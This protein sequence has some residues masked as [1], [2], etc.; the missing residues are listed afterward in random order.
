MPSLFCLFSVLG[1]VGFD[2]VTQGKTNKIVSLYL[3]GRYLGETHFVHKSR[4]V[5][6]LKN[7]EKQHVIG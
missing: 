4:A 7:K 6:R 2:G 1:R 5:T 3:F